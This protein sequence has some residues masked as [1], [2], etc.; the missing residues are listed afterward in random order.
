MAFVLLTLAKNILGNVLF[1]DGMWDVKVRGR[2]HGLFGVA[3]IML[4]VIEN[5]IAKVPATV[6]QYPFFFHRQPQLSQG[7][8]RPTMTIFGASK[9]FERETCDRYK[10]TRRPL[11]P[12][13]SATASVSVRD[14]SFKGL[15]R[16]L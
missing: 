5:S 3:Q 12:A 11:V 4:C 9:T 10:K 15:F 1:S 13:T 14:R 7:M 2:P 8:S 6:A 16:S